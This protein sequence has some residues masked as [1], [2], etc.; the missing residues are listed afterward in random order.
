MKYSLPF[1]P[2]NIKILVYPTKTAVCPYLAEGEPIPSGPCNQVIVTGS[3]ACKSLNIL[4][5]APLPP[6]III[7]EPAKTAEWPYLGSG[8]VPDIL[9]FLIRK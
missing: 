7:L 2:P 6:K 4:P 5:F 3:R 8:G 1:V 9:G